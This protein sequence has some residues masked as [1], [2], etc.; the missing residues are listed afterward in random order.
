VL[1]DFS[2]VPIVMGEFSLEACQRLASA[3]SKACKGKDVLFIASSDM[4]HYY[5]YPV[6]NLIDEK[7]NRIIEEFSPSKLWDKLAS[8]EVEMCGGAPVTTVMMVAKNFGA[9]KAKVLHYANS[10]DVTTDK[11]DR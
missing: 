8:G 5:E 9:D 1:G 3:L 2:L 6:A 11:D 7:A 4:S 10:G